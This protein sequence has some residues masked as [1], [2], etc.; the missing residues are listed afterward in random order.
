[1]M[2][3]RARLYFAAAFGGRIKRDPN[4]ERS[5][6][7]REAMNL[8]FTASHSKYCERTARTGKIDCSVQPAFQQDSALQKLFY[9][10][11]ASDYL[12]TTPINAAC[13]DGN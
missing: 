3:G 7:A 9:L 10:S 1:M 8:V 13:F 2:S 4:A 11:P 6:A 12:S 5:W